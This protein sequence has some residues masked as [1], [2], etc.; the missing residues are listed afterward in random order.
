MKAPPAARTEPE[1]R[2]ARRL[3][4]GD[5]VVLGLGSMLGAGVFAVLAPAADAAGAGLLVGLGIAGVVA[6]AN[7]SSSADLAALYPASGGTYVYGRVRL[8]PLWGFVAGWG[9]VVGKLASLAA[10]ALTFGE[11]VAPGAARPLAVA[12]VVGATAL[13]LGGIAKTAGVTRVI[14]A[15]VIAV[16]AAVVVA[17]LTGSALSW[18]PFE[19]PWPGGAYGILQSAGLLFFAFAGYARIATL[20]EEVRDPSR[21]IPRAVPL[22][23]G[24]VLAVY[25]LVAVGA[26]MALGPEAL[27]RASAPLAAAV[28][29]A[30]AHAL[31][32]I[33]RAGA[34]VAS[35][36]V[37]VSL[38]AGVSRTTFAMASEGDLPRF[39]AAV[40]ERT[41]VPHRA[42]L[43][44]GA[45]VVV[46]V[47]LVDLRNAI[48]F[49]SFAVLVYYAIA[50]AAALTLGPGERRH[51]RA[52]AAFGVLGC[53]VLAATLPARSVA[54]GGG[55]LLAG[56][57]IFLVRIRSGRTR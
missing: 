13:N 3:G 10:M 15:F 31:A 7:A 57:V 53:G 6:Y 2:L 56:I 34:A 4:L 43:L 17:C 42:E 19:R 29:A 25:A 5:A 20:G 41:R 24:I 46:T 54:V 8:G 38:V 36:G 39:A 35:L 27:A 22:A 32:P 21:T 47:A 49:S 33:V 16:L 45:V 55:V 37:L 12:A 18:A 40:H 30:G 1:S 52:L 51:P 9:F 50:N 11:Y 23:L 26:L 44:V 28:D 48:G 14:V